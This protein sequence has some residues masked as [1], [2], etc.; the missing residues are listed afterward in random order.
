M[1]HLLD[2]MYKQTA[3]SIITFDVGRF[4]QLRL[5]GQAYVF[6]LDLDSILSEM[7]HVLSL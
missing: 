6:E 4:E 2:R 1:S 7:K 3:Y 5:L